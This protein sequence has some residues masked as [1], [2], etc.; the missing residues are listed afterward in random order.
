MTCILFFHHMFICVPYNVLGA[1][2][3]IGFFPFYFLYYY[4]L[5]FLSDFEHIKYKF[6]A[7]KIKVSDINIPMAFQQLSNDDQSS[8]LCA[9]PDFMKQISAYYLICEYFTMYCQ[10]TR[11]LSWQYHH[12]HAL[13]N[14]NNNFLI[15]LTCYCS[16]F[17]C[18]N[19]NF[20]EVSNILVYYLFLRVT[21]LYPKP[22]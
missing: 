20:C 4:F 19:G 16:C 1:K 11:T 18:M 9:H 17:P 2:G 12:F 14:I 21:S 13:R 15:W 3:S 7:Y 8:F 5:L 22:V 6:Q 10:K